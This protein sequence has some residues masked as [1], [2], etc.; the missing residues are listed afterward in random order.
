MPPWRGERDAMRDEGHTTDRLQEIGSD[1]GAQLQGTEME[2][3]AKEIQSTAG[4][5]SDFSTLW[6]PEQEEE[7]A[8]EKGE[9]RSWSD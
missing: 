7:S 9:P 2:G 6:E 3:V 1:P 8:A 4:A 5:A